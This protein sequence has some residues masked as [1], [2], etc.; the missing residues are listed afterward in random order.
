[1]KKSTFIIL[2]VT[3]FL[4]SGALGFFGTQLIRKSIGTPTVS[5]PT[6]NGGGNV[7]TKAKSTV[8]TTPMAPPKTQANAQPNPQPSDE[9]NF[10]QREEKAV[11]QSARSIIDS[12]STPVIESVGKTSRV[13]GAKN[14]YYNLTG[15]KASV[16]SDAPLEY[17]LSSKDD[18]SFKMTSSSGSFSEVP[19]SRSGTY[20]LT[21]YNTDK[22]KKSESAIVTGFSICEP[23]RSLS[24]AELQS[25]YLMGTWPKDREAFESKFKK[26]Y[27]ITYKGMDTQSEINALPRTHQEL[28]QKF[29]TG[30]W[31]SL[32]ITEVE[33]DALGYITSFNVNYVKQ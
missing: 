31:S 21:V 11:R 20:I 28:F 1:M 30:I 24:K 2:L 10:E 16:G 22:A 26:G 23:I 12:L 25:I 15:I 17:V 4:A 3:A 33:Y 8:R 19:P 18:P 5:A 14:Y 29:R 9:P 13:V 6:I 27:K 32:S 7:K